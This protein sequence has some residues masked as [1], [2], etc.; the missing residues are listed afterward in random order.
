MLQAA[1]SAAV[2]SWKYW[3][4]SPLT[5]EKGQSETSRLPN[6]YTHRWKLGKGTHSTNKT[7]GKSDI[8]FLIGPRARGYSEEWKAEI[9]IWLL[10]TLA[11]S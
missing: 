6:T 4:I 5:F 2:S 8:Q 11:V 7:S 9:R 3:R 1:G 10:S